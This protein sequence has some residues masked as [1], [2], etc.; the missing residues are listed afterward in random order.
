MKLYTSTT[1]KMQSKVN[2]RLA[3]Q[4]DIEQ[5]VAI[6]NICFG[7]Q[8]LTKQHISKQFEWYKYNYVAV[9]DANVVGFCFA[10]ILSANDIYKIYGFSQNEKQNIALIKTIAVHPEYQRNKIASKLLNVIY[11]ELQQNESKHKL[12]YPCWNEPVSTAFCNSLSHLGFKKL[13]Q[14][15][16]FWYVDSLNNNYNCIKCGSPPCKCSLLLYYS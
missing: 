8:Y 1:N 9:I 5:I 13:K 15:D 4:K 7:D 12:L 3:D 2:I 16:N 11:C 14:I 6:S 10:Q